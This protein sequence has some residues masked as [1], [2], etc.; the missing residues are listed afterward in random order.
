MSFP[1]GSVFLK[2]AQVNSAGPVDMRTTRINWTHDVFISVPTSPS[3]SGIPPFELDYMGTDSP[4]IEL[5]GLIDLLDTTGS[6]VN[7]R[8]LTQFA[9]ATG[10]TWYSDQYFVASG[11]R[12]SIFTTGSV[13]VFPKSIS[14]NVEANN[15]QE[16]TYRMVL[17]LTSG[18]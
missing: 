4:G 12:K 6:T 9:Q 8:L 3:K 5:E 2:N 15:Q 18:T 7:M 13:G 1:M 11:T 10:P 14:A 17:I 16:I